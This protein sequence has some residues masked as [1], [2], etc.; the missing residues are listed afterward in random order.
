MCIRDRPSAIVDALSDDHRAVE[1]VE[2][3]PLLRKLVF[4]CYE[5][6]PAQPGA[7]LTARLDSEGAE[8]DA[9]V[10]ERIRMKPN[11]FFQNVRRARRLLAECL[12]MQGVVL[13]SVKRAHTPPP[14]RP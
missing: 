3:D 8:P 5:K 12:E 7:A 2:V 14:R 4:D 6:L 1:L 11:T 10:A 13:P 9:I